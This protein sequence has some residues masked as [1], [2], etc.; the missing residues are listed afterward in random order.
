M[1]IKFLSF[2]SIRGFLFLSMIG[3]ADG[4][5]IN[6]LTIGGCTNQI[7]IVNSAQTITSPV[8]VLNYGG[9]A[10]VASCSSGATV[11]AGKLGVSLDVNGTLISGGLG[12]IDRQVVADLNSTDQIT[13]GM[14]PSSG[15]IRFFVRL[16]GT[17]QNQTSGIGSPF[18]SST[19]Q[20]FFGGQNLVTN[21]GRS[22][23]TPV[24]N[25]N[26][27]F[28][29]DM[30]YSANTLNLNTYLSANVSCRTFQNGDACASSI[31]ALNSASVLR[32]IVLNAGGVEVSGA[33]LFGDSGFNYR[34]GIQGNEVPEPGAAVLIGIGLSAVL[35]GR[36]IQRHRQ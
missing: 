6:S 36:L 11:S 31:S 35:I 3:V 24:Q 12:N 22:D 7:T 23:V 2:P 8:Q 28:V 29:V 20:Y 9:G 18:A 25:L 21:N 17:I 13:V 10:G 5:T 30:P 19:L 27:P 4:A 34:L 15:T 26:L 32:A 1:A 16:E 14:A 33:T